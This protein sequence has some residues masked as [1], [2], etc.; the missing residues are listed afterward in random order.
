[1]QL[2]GQDDGAED[3]HIYNRKPT[4]ELTVRLTVIHKKKKWIQKVSIKTGKVDM[5]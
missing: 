5:N 1:M 4:P 2:A 3:F